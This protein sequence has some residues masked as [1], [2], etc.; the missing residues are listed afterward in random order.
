MAQGRNFFDAIGGTPLIRLQRSAVRHRLR[1][2]E[3]GDSATDQQECARSQSKGNGINN[4][5]DAG[6][7]C[8]EARS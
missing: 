5:T 8:C 6:T 1:V 4:R 2:T 3:P 7:E